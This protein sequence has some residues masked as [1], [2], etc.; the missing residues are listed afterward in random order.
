MNLLPEPT[1]EQAALIEQAQQALNAKQANAQRAKAKAQRQRDTGG[2]RKRWHILNAFCDLPKQ[3]NGL[4]PG[5][6]ALWLVMFRHADRKGVV[7]LAQSRM[8]AYTGLS[9]RGVQLA[10][11]RLMQKGQI[12][13][14]KRGGPN[15][16]VAS[17]K[18]VYRVR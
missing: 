5:D 13:Q 6:T 2:N 12:E 1:P 11:K 10:L 8:Q 3:E 18:M 7:A 16:G 9:R 15:S 17:Y 4:R 14:M